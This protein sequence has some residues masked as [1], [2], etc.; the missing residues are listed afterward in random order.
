M[1]APGMGLLVVLFSIVAA[2][3]E[4][5]SNGLEGSLFCTPSPAFIICRLVGDGYSSPEY[6]LEG[7][8]LEAPILWLPDV[9]N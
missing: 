3:T 9:K 1:Y 4:I 2:P 8:M 7:L 6:S 5:L